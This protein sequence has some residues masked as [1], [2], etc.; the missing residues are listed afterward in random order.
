[1]PERMK[2][3]VLH[4]I[5]DLR[6]EEV[7]VP[8]IERDDEV[9]IRIRAV[10]VCGSDIHYYREGRIGK[11]VVTEPLILGH[12]SAG[13]VVEVG[14]AVKHLKPG[15]KVAIEP[16]V[17]CRRCEFCHQGRYN[18]CPDEAFM[19]TPPT[20]GAFAEYVV[21]PA[22]FV[23]KL[24][25]DAPYEAGALCEPLAVALHAVN[26][27]QLRPASTV[28]V[29]G[30]GPIGLALIQASLASGASAVCATDVYPL[31]LE[32][33]REM[34][35][36]L[37]INAKEADAVESIMDA[38]D[39]KGADVVFEAA[40]SIVTQRQAFAAVKSRGMIVLVGMT[41]EDTNEVP[42]LDLIIREY[43]VR[44]VLRYANTYPQAVAFTATGKVNLLPM[45]THHF[46]LEQAVEALEVADTQKDKAIK[47]MVTVP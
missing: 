4:A 34:G 40:G 43:Q 9:L 36:A 23:F 28:A 32:K 38:T 35:A 14:S 21:W 12:E 18:L 27:A 30:C 24:P 19:A 5:N 6:I 22:D 1:M 25:D 41:P 10:G 26:L 44:G 20:H 31:R 29:L 39:G 13:E 11:F 45:V 8:K 37:T 33:A 42:L 7:E 3:A 46:T 17:G 16:G 47:V 2:A 15:D